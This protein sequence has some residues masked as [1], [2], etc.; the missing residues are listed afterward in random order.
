MAKEKATVKR[1]RVLNCFSSRETHRDWRFEHAILAGHVTEEALSSVP[2]SVDLRKGCEEWW[3]IGDQGNTGSCVGWATADSLLRW[4]FVKAKRL[5]KSNK[6]S[7][8]FIWM[9][10]KEM[11]ADDDHYYPSTFLELE[12]TSLKSA[13]GIAKNYGAVEEPVLPFKP[14][15]LYQD[16]PE[17]FLAL[18]SRL[19]ILNYFNLSSGE[20]DAQPP[21][22]DKVRTWI[23]NKGPVLTRLDV[24]DTWFGL[25]QTENPGKY[26]LDVYHK[27]PGPAGHAV[28]LVGYTADSFIVRNSWG[29]G[30]GDKGYGYASLEYTQAAFT[31]AYGVGLIP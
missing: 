21:D 2:D 11:E 23:A 8:R 22:W 28:A 4:Y 20:G 19:K 26:N 25:D 14:E 9:A 27:P 7:V 1:N 24:D 18:A 3:N 13:L 10:A 17:T 29:E 16:Q 31:E 6:L 15:V 12:G 5:A 30:W